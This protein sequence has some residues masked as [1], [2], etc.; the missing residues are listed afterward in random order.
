MEFKPGRYVIGIWFLAGEGHDFQ[1]SV[2]TDDPA[3]SKATAWEAEWRF[4]YYDEED[5]RNDPFSGKDR[6]SF[7]HG[8][9]TGSETEAFEHTEDTIR[10]M[11]NMPSWMEKKTGMSYRE[12]QFM[13]LY[14]SNIEFIIEQLKKQPWAHMK[15]L[16]KEEYD[17]LMKKEDE[18][19]A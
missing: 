7:W 4:R 19:D 8:T 10:K 11:V 18:E 1:M 9:F 15:E 17:E 5:P 14:S 16:T 6:K 2:W 12:K 3:E 13:P